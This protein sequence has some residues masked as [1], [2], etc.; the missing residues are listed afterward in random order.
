MDMKVAASRLPRWLVC[1]AVLGVFA[2]NGCSAQQPAG[3]PN[4]LV[5]DSSKTEESP[6][7]FEVDGVRGEFYYTSGPRVHWS[8]SSSNA[9]ATALRAYV[10][11]R[12]DGKQIDFYLPR[13]DGRG[14]P[15]YWVKNEL[16]I[17]DISSSQLGSS[18]APYAPP[19]SP[20]PGS[21]RSI[22][23]E[24]GDDFTF[25]IRNIEVGPG[26]F[27]ANAP[28]SVEPPPPTFDL[29]TPDGKFNKLAAD[30][31][32]EPPSSFISTIPDSPY[33]QSD[34]DQQPAASMRSFIT[35]VN[36]WGDSGYATTSPTQIFQTW[37]KD[38]N[39]D[40]LKAG[41]DLLG[42]PQIRE[43]YRRVQAGD[44]EIWFGNGTH[45]VG[46][47]AGQIPPGTYRCSAP[48]GQ[49]IKN[50]YWERTSPA[51]DII[52]NNF[53]TSAQSTT[54]T[55]G[56]SDGQFTSSRMGTWRPID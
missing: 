16:L 55:I 5:I 14:D 52:E 25:I 21:T 17:E 27:T 7:A 46:T 35:Q 4:E 34:P 1:I 3:E 19:T 23:S 31:D 15:D 22:T 39:P 40:M 43:T 29:S 2:L 49:L 53:V 44:I 38:W 30:K 45:I 51:G 41:L 13:N 54:V 36:E 20:E 32:W 28:V 50:G 12:R 33:Y 6:A 18:F 37:M 56:A 8:M 10:E 26:R 47:G 24:T 11:L 9:S 42:D 48:G